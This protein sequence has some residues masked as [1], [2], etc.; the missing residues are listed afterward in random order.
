MLKKSSR[1]NV[2]NVYFNNFCNINTA[3]NSPHNC[4]QESKFLFTIIFV[5]KC[6]R[7]KVA[8]RNH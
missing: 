6:S 3:V 7:S 8:T 4:Y 2:K 5:E 1:V